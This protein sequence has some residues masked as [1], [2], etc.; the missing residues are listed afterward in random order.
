MH[1]APLK[2]FIAKG[3]LAILGTWSLQVVERG[4]NSAMAGESE[5]EGSFEGGPH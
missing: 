2:I 1:Y 5:R 4:G 3:L